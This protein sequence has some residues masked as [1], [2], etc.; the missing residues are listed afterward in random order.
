MYCLDA[1]TGETIWKFRKFTFFRAG[2]FFSP[3]IAD[4]KVYAGFESMHI[5]NKAM[6]FCFGE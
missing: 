6:L 4:G 3:A 5:G 1:F 2:S